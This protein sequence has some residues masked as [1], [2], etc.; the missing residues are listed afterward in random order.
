MDRTAW[1]LNLREPFGAALG[2][3]L[4]SRGWT[5]VGGDPESP[6]TG[7]DWQIG[8][9]A[10]TQ[11]D[12]AAHRAADDGWGGAVSPETDS[13]AASENDVQAE[14][15][16][17]RRSGWTHGPHIGEN[18]DIPTG[19]GTSGLNDFEGSVGFGPESNAR[20]KIGEQDAEYAAETDSPSFGA[21]PNASNAAGAFVAAETA[22]ET[23][24][25]HVTDTSASVERTLSEFDD[26]LP[27]GAS[28]LSDDVQPLP[29]HGRLHVLPL[30]AG[31]PDAL[32]EA[33]RLTADLAGRI[34]LLVLN[35]GEIAPT[36]E[37]AEEA[38]AGAEA[39]VE[40][41][42]AEADTTDERLLD[43]ETYALTPLRVIERLLP[44]MN[45]EEGLK[46]ICFVS[47]REGS[48]SAGDDAASMGR[49]MA[50]TAL[51]MQARLLFNDLHREG[52]TFRLYDPGLLPKP[53]VGRHE[54]DASS[55][56]NPPMTSMPAS[57]AESARFA[58]GLFANPHANEE[59]L[60][61]TGSRGE[62]WPF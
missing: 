47:S 34:D 21:D 60:V 3:E 53:S 22:P 6:E 44:L 50:Y 8:G 36:N 61:L 4:V 29:E 54:S 28:S 58:A 27:S 15:A 1:I 38:A 17:K 51:H 25:E 40:N 14:S 37:S 2:R 16:E 35:V 55:A 20:P 33:V 30:E 9:K 11:N 31:E 19:T 59:R 10:K 32:K 5:V 52:Y 13:L 7:T 18:A 12:A 56:S 43:Y 46:R 62:E 49:A 42:E 39:F 48:I 41:F 57:I 23:V 26:S 45:A 24:S